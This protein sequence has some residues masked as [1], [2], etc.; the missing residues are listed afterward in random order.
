MATTSR[1]P[2]K[3][4]Q[5]LIITLPKPGKEPTI[6]Q[7]FRP[8]SLLK[9][10][11]KMYAKTITTRLLN[12]IP[13]LIHR[14]QSGRQASDAKRRLID[15]THYAETRGTP[16]LLLSLDAD[17]AFDR[18]HWRYLQQV[19]QKFGFKGQILNALLALY[20]TLSAQVF[21]AD[22][23]FQPFTITNGTRQGC[24]LSPLIFNL[25]MKPHGRTH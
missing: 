25:L 24:L 10:D 21:S 1:F 22:M 3:S 6:P 17:K 13:M 23:L 19:L 16:S 5:A 9:L 11:L 12:V 4:L 2:R 15:I 7:N 14:D 20:T 18:I 8:I